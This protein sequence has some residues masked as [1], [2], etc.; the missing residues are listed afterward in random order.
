MSGRPRT[1]VLGAGPAGIAAAFF[2][3]RAGHDVTLIEKADFVGGKGAS[4]REGRYV[5]D[6]GPHAYHPKSEAINELIVSHAGSGYILRKV[7]MELVLKGKRLAYPFRPTEGLR[8]FHPLFTLRIV[9]DYLATRL[10]DLVSPLPED[11]FRAYGVKHFGKTLYDLCFGDY[12]ERVW[13]V[14]AA[15]ISPELARRKLPRFSLTA[16]L[17]ERFL[18]RK[19]MDAH[20]ITPEVG[21]HREGIGTIYRNVVEDFVGKGGTLRTETDVSSVNWDPSSR[22]ATGVTLPSG[23]RLG[24]DFLVST[25][26]ITALLSRLSVRP[27]ELVPDPRIRYR[28]ILLL[29]VFLKKERFSRA[30]WTYLVDDRF[31][32][33]RISEQKNLSED[34]CPADRTV[35]TLEISSA[36]DEPSWTFS[37]EDF[38]PWI[39]EDLSFFGIVREDVERVTVAHLRDAY[40]IYYKGYEDEMK[41]ILEALSAIQNLVTTGR[42]GLYLDIG[43]HDAMR[44][45]LEAVEALAAGA[46]QRFYESHESFL[47]RK[48]NI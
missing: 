43:M 12:T 28:H 40:P 5:L 13:G 4:R 3:Q 14:S 15:D 1:I 38:L 2:A 48:T 7:H 27:P 42:Q 25:I 8:N 30:H 41:R 21:Y 17:T 26:P 11:S 29:Y 24:C 16:L 45:G 22:R 46:V 33:H 18:K 23:G 39:L 9:A 31:H 6:F 47:P 44:L 34:C 20:I 36:E 32:F 35:L 19:K 37:G 10:R